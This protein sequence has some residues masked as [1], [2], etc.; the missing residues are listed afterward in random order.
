[1][2][3]PKAVLESLNHQR[4]KKTGKVNMVI[5]TANVNGQVSVLMNQTQIIQL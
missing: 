3:A 1:M 2:F 4:I 5:I